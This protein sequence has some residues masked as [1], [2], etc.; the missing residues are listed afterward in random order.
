ME[1]DSLAE[2]AEKIDE[3]PTLTHMDKAILFGYFLQ[4]DRKL[5][6]FHSN[7]ILECYGLLDLPPPAN[8]ADL[9]S[10]AKKQKRLIPK[11]GGYRVSITEAQRIEHLLE[12]LD[13]ELV[14]EEMP[15][16]PSYSREAAIA[17][18]KR[19]SLL[20]RKR[21]FRAGLYYIVLIDLVG[22][23]R[24]S[25][26]IKP[27]ENV[28]R[29]NQF[30]DFTKDALKAIKHPERAQFIKEIGDA[31]LFTFN[32]FEDILEWSKNLDER[33]EAYNKE[34]EH[35]G[36]PTIFQMFT[37]KCVHLGEVH[38]D[39]VSNPIAFAINQVFKIE[40][41]F[42]KDQ[43]G[44]TDSVRQVILPRIKAKQIILNKVIDVYLAGDEN[45]S[46]LWSISLTSM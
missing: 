28:K 43:L 41:E 34:C 23:T 29:I 25:A 15:N 17:A 21:Q 2:F 11:N 8:I 40:K 31:S 27:D 38:F 16:V 4:T 24:A 20:E 42:T 13:F 19:I 7:E 1:R 6:K 37:K 32:N 22:S 45:P 44:I 10:K 26:E 5:D 18:V 30:V 33:L 46:P 3:F 12:A 35:T 9:L 39:K 36:K 14:T